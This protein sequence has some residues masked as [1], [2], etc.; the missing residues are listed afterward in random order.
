MPD[1][2]RGV[3]CRRG[4]CD[5]V[6]L[7]GALADAAKYPAAGVLPPEAL[8]PI[9]Q[10]SRRRCGGDGYTSFYCL[11]G[12]PRAVLVRR[13]ARRRSG[14]RLRLDLHELLGARIRHARVRRLV[15]ARSGPAAVFD[16]LPLFPRVDLLELC[17]LR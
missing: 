7:S 13:P 8:G 11:L 5:R 6:F 10:L 2:P 12:E 4:W 17:E 9:D 15:P 3:L 14:A 1:H 16:E